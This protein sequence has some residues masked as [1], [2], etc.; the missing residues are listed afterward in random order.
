MSGNTL[1]MNPE[2]AVCVT[3]DNKSIKVHCLLYSFFEHNLLCVVT[4]SGEFIE[5]EDLKL[6][7]FKVKLYDRTNI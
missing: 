6:L 5:V 2:H 1:P 3:T 7:A 4:L